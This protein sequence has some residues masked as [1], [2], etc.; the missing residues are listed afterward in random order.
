MLNTFQNLTLT[1]VDL[2][3]TAPFPPAMVDVMTAIWGCVF[4]GISVLAIY[5]FKQG[6]GKRAGWVGLAFLIALVVSSVFS[7][8][9]CINLLPDQWCAPIPMIG[10][11][12]TLV[13]MAA[14]LIFLRIRCLLIS[15]PAAVAWCITITVLSG[16]LGPASAA[17]VSLP[18]DVVCDLAWVWLLFGLSSMLSAEYCAVLAVAW[19]RQQVT[20]REANR[21]VADHPREAVRR[22]P[23]AKP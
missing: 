10:M 19:H 14:G 21:T 2:P 9:F 15:L 11:T 17:V 1:H 22:I 12:V 13:A 16:C 5:H 7:L 23:S 8:A 6:L 3:G 20:D 4:A 18:V